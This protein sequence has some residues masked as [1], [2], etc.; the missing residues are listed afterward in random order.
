MRKFVKILVAAVFSTLIFCSSIPVYAGSITDDYQGQKYYSYWR[1]TALYVTYTSGHY[2]VFDFPSNFLIT[3]ET[4][5]QTVSLTSRDLTKELTFLITF[6]DPEDSAIFEVPVAE[7]LFDFTGIESIDFVFDDSIIRT[8]TAL[9]TEAPTNPY[10]IAP[11][12]FGGDVDRIAIYSYDFFYTYPDKTQS[13]YEFTFSHNIISKNDAPFVQVPGTSLYYL[14]ITNDQLSSVKKLFTD[15]G[16]NDN[17]CVPYFQHGLV[18]FS[19]EPGA[20]SNYFDVIL[21]LAVNNYPLFAA[22]TSTVASWINLY[23][24]GYTSLVPLDYTFASFIGDVLGGFFSIELFFGLSLGTIVVS[25]F[26]VFFVKAFL[27]YFAGG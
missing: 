12:M 8:Y 18:S 25:I 11:P 23:F 20:S 14:G 22:Y 6:V 24:K 3:E 27:K 15:Q 4:V 16:Y 9:E 21:P 10:P 7:V 13:E 5:E 1:C 19:F 26:A 17:Y 2:A